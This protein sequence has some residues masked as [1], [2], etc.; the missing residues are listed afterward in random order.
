M[1]NFF[2]ILLDLSQLI[3]ILCEFKR[4]SKCIS[5]HLIPNVALGPGGSDSA[6]LL[7]LKDV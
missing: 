6:K 3:R 4:E 1:I 7:I 2:V 5:M